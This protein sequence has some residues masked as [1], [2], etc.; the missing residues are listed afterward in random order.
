MNPQPQILCGVVVSAGKMMRAVKVR[1]AKQTYNGFLKKHF[2]T[3]NSYLVSDPN[4]SLRT[5]DVVKITNEKR[6]S[7]HIKH[8]VTE[9]VA[10]WGP[11]IEE[12]PKVLS[13]E[14]RYEKWRIRKEAKNLRKAARLNAEVQ[15][16]NDGASVEAG[17]V[18]E[19]VAATAR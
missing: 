11:A 5:G 4:D 3:H 17:E 10:P 6:V 9:I 14:E 7:R 15:G 8:V 16:V 13:T 18:R 1:T 12:R 19:K 2:L